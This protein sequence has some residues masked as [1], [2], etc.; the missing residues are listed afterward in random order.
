MTPCPIGRPWHRRLPESQQ[1]SMVREWAQSN[2]AQAHRIARPDLLL[3]DYTVKKY[4]YIV[5]SFPYLTEA[6]PYTF[7]SVNRRNKEAQ[8]HIAIVHVRRCVQT[9]LV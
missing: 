9:L 7:V 3:Y 6:V 8:F 1:G 2:S 5:A 4:P